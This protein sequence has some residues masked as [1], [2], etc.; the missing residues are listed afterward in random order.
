MNEHTNERD[1]YKGWNIFARV[2]QTIL[3]KRGLGLGHLDDR[4]IGIHPQKVLRLKRSLT[5]PK[6]FPV[7]RP[8]EMED[9]IRTFELSAEE[10]ILLRAAVLAT[11]I[12]E[13]LMDRI[14]NEDALN[15]AEL[16]LPI[17]E[18]A[19]RKDLGLRVTIRG[20]RGI[21]QGDDESEH[22]LA[23]AVAT[24]DHATLMLHLSCTA[25]TGASRIELA[26]QAEAGFESSLARLNRAD[27]ELMTS[28]SGSAWYEE[29]RNGLLAARARLAEI[30][31]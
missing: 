2:L 29:A 22:L 11:A 31:E 8:D 30:G 18:D 1:P 17:I 5:S 28:E 10:Q 19:I 15:G 7:L 25:Q 16:L 24:I 26:R 12:E 14:N 20:N 3:E 4:G 27:T 6:R 13:E 21:P 9:V 23:E